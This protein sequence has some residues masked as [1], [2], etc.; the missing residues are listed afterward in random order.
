MQLRIHVNTQS[1]TTIRAVTTVRR[2]QRNDSRRRDNMKQEREQDTTVV[3]CIKRLS[4][5]SQCFDY[6]HYQFITSHE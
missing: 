1:E 2:R 5:S 4:N 6:L 3:H